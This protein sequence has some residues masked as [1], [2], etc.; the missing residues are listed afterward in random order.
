M[1]SAPVFAGIDVS[2]D[3]LDIALRPGPA[4]QVR[5]DKAGLAQLQRKLAAAAPKVVVLEASGGYELAAA[6]ALEDAGVPVRIVNPRRVREFARG[7]GHLAKTDPID[8]QVLAFFAEVNRPEP[9]PRPSEQARRLSS[10]VQ[11]REQ[12]VAFVTQEPSPRPG[13]RRHRAIDQEP[14]PS[15][16]SGAG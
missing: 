14:H 4:W 13:G 2:K 10:L 15:A 1:D 8:A 9:R 5:N 6:D 12:V 7:T 11:R 3:H 16:Q